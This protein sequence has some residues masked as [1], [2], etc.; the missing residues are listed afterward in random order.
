MKTLGALADPTRQQIVELLARG[1]R[2]AGAIAGEF[3]VS[4]PAISRHLRVLREAGVIEARAD[5]KHRIYRVR[6]EAFDELEQWVLKYRGFWKRRL[7]N[8]EAHLTSEQQPGGRP[9]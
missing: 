3:P 6:P 2:D 8:L 4:R 1:E 5:G 7:D 9:T